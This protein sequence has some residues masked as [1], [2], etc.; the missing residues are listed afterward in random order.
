[1]EASGKVGA[2]PRMKLVTQ[3]KHRKRDRVAQAPP[4]Q[5]PPTQPPPTQ[6][7]GPLSVTQSREKTHDQP[8]AESA[9][10]EIFQVCNND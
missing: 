1:M 2:K 4:T 9:V 3:K 5:A 6:T 7:D 10:D 8:V